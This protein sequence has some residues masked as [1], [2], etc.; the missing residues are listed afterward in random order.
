MIT[1]GMY[2]PVRLQLGLATLSRKNKS[3]KNVDTAIVEFDNEKF[4]AEVGPYKMAF[5]KMGDPKVGKPQPVSVPASDFVGLNYELR[6][7]PPGIL[8]GEQP[9]STVE[10]TTRFCN[11]E[12]ELVRIA[13]KYGLNRKR[14]LQLPTVNPSAF[15]LFLAKI[16]HGFGVALV[17]IDNFR[18]RLPPLILDKSTPDTLPYLIGGDIRPFEQ[19]RYDHFITTSTAEVDGTRYYVVTVQLFA[20][21]GYPRYAVVIGEYLGPAHDRL[22]ALRQSES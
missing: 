15:L 9:T 2:L 10:V 12:T 3:R 17:G 5:R 14:G 16:A 1:G 20:M 6:L 13:A 7:P 21:L 8:L 4:D 19:T 11:S 18:H 22:H